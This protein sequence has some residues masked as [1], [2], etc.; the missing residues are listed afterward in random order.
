MPRLG[1]VKRL[2]D[3]K[4]MAC[5]LYVTDQCNLDCH[6]CAEYDNSVAHPRLEDL[7]R[8][9]TKARDFGCFHLGLQG[10]EPLLYPQLPEVIRYAKDLGFDVSASTNGYL[11]S[12]TVVRELEDAGLDKMQVSVDRMTPTESTRKA[13]KTIG[14]KLGH[15]RDSKI[16][17]QMSG[18]L[19]DDT[20]GECHEVL[21]TALDMGFSSHFRLVHP[22]PRQSFRVTVGERTRLSSFLEEMW[23]RK[24]GGEQIHTSWTILNYQQSL[25]EGK[26]L[27]WTCRA[28]YK[29][30]FI[31]SQGKFWP[32]SMVRTNLDI[33]DVT[34]DVLASYDRK[35]SCQESCGVYCVIGTSLLVDRPFRTA[36]RE[37]R[38][39]SRQIPIR[40]GLEEALAPLPDEVLDAAIGK[41]LEIEPAV[42]GSCV[43]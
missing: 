27:D 14:P 20:L 32:C 25:L 1:M 12:A 21:D 37:L 15:L 31:S 36:M 29:Y 3:R 43:A 17:T 23:N 18:V 2:Y 33:E 9:I 6:Y 26:S 8:W 13:L 35:K 24:S 40:T 5:H 10:G 42:E 34:Q 28:G 7:K 16:K 11:L 4:P 41:G 19:F 22:D 30:F 39:G 38:V